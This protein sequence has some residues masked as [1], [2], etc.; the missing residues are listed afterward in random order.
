MT[1]VE[2]VV[3]VALVGSV[4][5]T[6]LV[7]VSR[8]VRQARLAQDRLAALRHA[9]AFLQAWLVEGVE[10]NTT[11]GPITER[12]GWRWRLSGRQEPGLEVFGAHVGRI[13]ILREDDHPLAKLEFVST[14][15]LTSSTGLNLR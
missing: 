7:S 6:A 13:E 4:L 3:A 14:S 5:A 2:V 9:D 1:L 12:E 15:P 11:E 8:H 10:R